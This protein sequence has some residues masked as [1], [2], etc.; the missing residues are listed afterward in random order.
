[1]CISPPRGVDFGHMTR[2]APE[3]LPRHEEDVATVA[4]QR[5][6]WSRASLRIA[7]LQLRLR[8]PRAGRACPRWLTT[9]GEQSPGL[10]LCRPGAG[11]APTHHGS[12]PKLRTCGAHREGSR[13]SPGGASHRNAERRV[14]RT[15]RGTNSTTSRG[16]E[17]DHTASGPS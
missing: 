5:G 2:F 10:S 4:A 9:E 8:T 12:T 3:H 15:A 16:E 14:L 13:R 11:D 17:R 1:M 7:A 6:P